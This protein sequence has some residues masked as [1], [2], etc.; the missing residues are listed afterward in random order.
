MDWLYAGHFRGRQARNTYIVEGSGI[1]KKQLAVN[2]A[3][4]YYAYVNLS[5]YERDVYAKIARLTTHVAG[6][7]KH[8]LIFD[9]KHILGIS[10]LRC[11]NK[12]IDIVIIHEA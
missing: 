7:F 8:G 3:N 4:I 6:I 2:V 12:C 1:L 10:S 5:T 9:I 11:K